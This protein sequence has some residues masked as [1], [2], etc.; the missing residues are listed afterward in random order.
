MTATKHRAR[1][2][3]RA[4][5]PRGFTLIELLVVIAI[6]ALLIGILLPALGKV[7]ATAR[8]LKD[9]TQIRGIHQSMLT[10]GQSGQDD[11][12]LPSKID[13]AQKTIALG[14]PPN[15]PD[16]TP[17]DIT[18][19]ILALLIHNGF[20][21]TEILINPAESNTGGVVRDDSYQF[22]SPTGAADTTQALWDPKFRATPIDTAV[23]GQQATDP[24]NQSYAHSPPIGK[25]R[26]R[27]SNSFNSTE[28]VFG[29]RGPVYNYI[30][31]QWIL[32]NSGSPPGAFG[33]QSNTLLIHGSRTKWEGN[34]AYND[35]HVQFETKPDPDGV[36][37]T[38][39]A[40]PPATRTQNDNLF[41][42]ESDSSG[43]QAADAPAPVGSAG[44]G[45]MNY[46]GGHIADYGNA[47]LR[48][49]KA[50]ALGASPPSS[51]TA[52][53]WVD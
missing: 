34:I 18:R 33:T 17:K 48:P 12:P 35:N 19:N 15:L 45:T 53:A 22:D 38:F 51:A 4:R 44:L 25:R 11:Y 6:I 1:T 21:P 20:I 43:G 30:N 10:W 47:L 7:R 50:M 42:N 13:K 2:I 39:T 3:A 26:A 49:W 8:Q 14:T 24:A 9:A 52:T 23:G 29:D 40:L 27:W 28:A 41:V 5:P 32:D 16:Q 31:G 37:Y 46:T 36:T